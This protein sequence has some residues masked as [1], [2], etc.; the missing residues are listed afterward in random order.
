MN[1]SLFPIPPGLHLAKICDPDIIKS[2]NVKNPK[3]PSE[4]IKGLS[5]NFQLELLDENRRSTELFVRGGVSLS[6]RQGHQSPIL[7]LA[8]AA[9]CYI[10]P[11]GFDK[12]EFENA[13]VM[14]EIELHIKPHLGLI[15][16]PV[17][18]F[19]A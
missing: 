5:M 7:R 11:D 14:V 13:V 8:N 17:N 4:F 12:A 10:D 1:A 2:P 3:R 6:S 9:G 16:V 19:K 15:A 18:Y